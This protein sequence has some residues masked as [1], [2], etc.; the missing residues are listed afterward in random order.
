MKKIITVFSL[1]M[2]WGFQ[3]F[4]QAFII[5]HNSTKILQIPEAAIETAKQNLHIAYGHTSHGSQLIFGM[6]DLIAFMNGNGYT[7]NLY[8]W[9]N[10]GTDGALDLHDEAM[11]GDVGYYPDW[12]NNTRSYLGDPDPETGRGTGENEDVNVIIW[13]W[14]G[15]VASQSESSMIS[16][17][18][19][20][21]TEL[22]ADY[23]GIKFV[24]MTGHLDGSGASGNLNLRNEQIRAYCNDNNKILYDFADIESY[25]PD[26]ET[27]YMALMANDNC[28]YDS[29]DNGSLDKNWATEWQNSHAVDTDWYEC[30]A[31][32]SQALNGNLKA[33]AA[34]WLWASIA[35]WNQGTGISTGEQNSPV[36]SVFPNPSNGKL[37]VTAE[38]SSINTIEI[39]NLMGAK[40]FYSTDIIPLSTKE[41]DLYG[42]ANGIYVIKIYGGAK[43]YTKKIVIQ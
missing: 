30:Y 23:P 34:W 41:I 29:D 38:N 22:E 19:A 15:Q 39:Y 40:V 26:G 5:N 33:Y 9:N 3:T 1:A 36:V 37:M 4:S 24:Y 8:A 17:Y 16:N 27:D 12:V 18:L 43:I 35:G 6:N 42:L 10:G 11:S 21:M 25:D 13:S 2:L 14:C 7:N 32:H 20:P 31:A 28:D